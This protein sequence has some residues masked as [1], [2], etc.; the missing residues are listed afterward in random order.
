MRKLP[1]FMVIAALLSGF[2]PLGAQEDTFREEV[3]AIQSADDLLDYLLEE[4]G[5]LPA[6]RIDTSGDGEVDYILVSEP[7]GDKVL[8]IMDYDRNGKM[9]DFC[10][11]GKGVQT[12]RIID[13]NSDGLLDLWVFIKDGSY[14]EE[15]R[16]DRDFDGVVDAVKRYGEE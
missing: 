4:E 7:D 6:D 16:Q 9:D 1:L 8:E 13:S 11:Y 5:S 15:F 2:A 14:V 12:M 3:A 10:V